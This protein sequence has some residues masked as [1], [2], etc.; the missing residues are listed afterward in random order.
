MA[1][2]TLS[3]TYGCGVR[4]MAR[5]LAQRLGYSLFEKEFIPLRSKRLDRKT[6]GS[7]DSL[8]LEQW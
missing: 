7:Q 8:H 3:R 5:E 4:E 6:E 2:L 1:I